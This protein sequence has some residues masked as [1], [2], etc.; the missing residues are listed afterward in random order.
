MFCCIFAAKGFSCSCV[1]LVPQN[2]LLAAS[3]NILA[4]IERHKEHLETI[5]ERI[6]Y[7]LSAIQRTNQELVDLKLIYEHRSLYSIYCPSE[8]HYALRSLD[9]Y[10]YTF[11]HL[12]VLRVDLE[13]EENMYIE[14]LAKIRK[15]EYLFILALG[16]WFYTQKDDFV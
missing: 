9:S 8:A 1:P 14:L 6:Q 11:T 5:K 3:S 13:Q 10:E 12:E 2:P 15:A 7:W 4:D 16:I